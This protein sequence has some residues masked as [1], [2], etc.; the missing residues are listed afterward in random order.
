MLSLHVRGSLAKETDREADSE[1]HILRW[2]EERTHLPICIPV[3]AERNRRSRGDRKKPRS[4][5]FAMA[6]VIISPQADAPLRRAPT[7]DDLV[8]LDQP[9]IPLDFWTDQPVLR[10]FLKNAQEGC[11]PTKRRRVSWAPELEDVRP[12]SPRVSKRAKKSDGKGDFH[13]ALMQDK[14]KERELIDRELHK[15]PAME[16]RSDWVEPGELPVPPKDDDDDEVVVVSKEA[17]RLARVYKMSVEVVYVRTAQ[18]P[19]E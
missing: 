6:Q 3:D 13:D 12:I 15:L 8:L 7:W 19:T 2:L 11:A 14:A 9:C 10:Q 17:S 18:V 4:A 1:L 16:A 5:S